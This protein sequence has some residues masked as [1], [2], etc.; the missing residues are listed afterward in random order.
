MIV[1]QRVRV[2]WGAG[3]R[4]APQA[5]L[6]RGLDRALPLPSSPPSSDVAAG[7]HAAAGKHAAGRQHTVA[8][9]HPVA[10]HAAAGKHAVDHDGV[11]LHDVLADEA[12][13]YEFRHR[14]V[15]GGAELA[16]EAG[17]WFTADGPAV[18]VGRGQKW[19]AFPSLGAARLFTVLPGQ[20]GRYRANFRFRVTTCPC[21]P[22]WYYENHVL[23][24]SNGYPDPGAFLQGE[25][26]RDVDDRVHLYGGRRRPAAARRAR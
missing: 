24:V 18:I 2:R 9:R 4:G 23:H 6:R 7:E 12:D 20:F 11:V 5:N 15:S 25:P 10:G 1:I 3:S 17:L 16:G 14:L 8:R 22:S 19:A 21:N 13:G 26:L